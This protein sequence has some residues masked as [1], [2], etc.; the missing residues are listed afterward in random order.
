MPFTMSIKVNVW[1]PTMFQDGV[2][3][4]AHAS[5]ELSDGTYISWAFRNN[6]DTRHDDIMRQSFHEDLK[7]EQRRPEK[8]YFIKPGKLEEEAMKAWWT[9]WWRDDVWRRQMPVWPLYTIF[10]ALSV[11][12]KGYDIPE[13]K[14]IYMNHKLLIG[15]MKSNKLIITNGT[16]VV[17]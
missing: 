8:T 15:Y 2:K 9:K 1:L 5:L 13:A 3:S 17:T 16:C 11:G 12:Q 6:D 4:K 7:R 14:G 10:E